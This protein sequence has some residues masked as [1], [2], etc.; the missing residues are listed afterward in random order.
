MPEGSNKKEKKRWIHLAIIASALIL[1]ASAAAITYAA[2]RSIITGDVSMFQAGAIRGA[3]Q[4]YPNEST[5][6]GWENVSGDEAPEGYGLS[7]VEQIPETD[8]SG[9]VIGSGNTVYNNQDWLAD[10]GPGEDAELNSTNE[11]QNRRLYFSVKSNVDG[12]VSDTGVIYNIRIYSSGILPL[13]FVLQEV[14]KASE[15]DD[16]TG[17]VPETV[18]YYYS[19][20]TSV[21]DATL[22]KKGYYTLYEFY[23]KDSEGTLGTDEISFSQL[24]DWGES[25]QSETDAEKNFEIYV[26]WDNDNN[27]AADGSLRKEVERLKVVVHLI[28]D[29]NEEHGNP[30][31]APTVAETTKAKVSGD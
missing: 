3:L 19:R 18:T 6:I 2:Y 9:N 24:L 30:S 16:G 20:K 15:T 10:L 21:T 13:Q 11:N 27:D 25:G 8:A 14:K 17:T 1:I 23:V 22:Q 12:T 31:E 5:A 29:P 4:L 28:N 7:W 26:G